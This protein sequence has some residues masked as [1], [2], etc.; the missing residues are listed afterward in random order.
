MNYAALGA[1]AVCLPMLLLYKEKYNRLSQDTAAEENV[2]WNSW[3][4]PTSEWHLTYGVRENSHSSRRMCFSQTK[5]TVTGSVLKG[6][7]N[8]TPC[9][10]LCFYCP[11]YLFTYNTHNL[12]KT[13]TVERCVG[14]YN[15]FNIWKGLFQFK[16]LYHVYNIPY[17]ADV[18]S[19]ILLVESLWPYRGF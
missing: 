16:K 4:Q 11:R 18:N 13:L 7:H 17:L 9:R 10:F 12:N 14:N 3:K 19:S 5:L 8:V 6:R 1:V 2:C 15:F